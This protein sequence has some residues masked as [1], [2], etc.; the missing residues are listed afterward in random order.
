MILYL[1]LRIATFLASNYLNF[2]IVFWMHEQWLSRAFNDDV[3]WPKMRKT[4]FELT[5]EY[6]VMC[7]SFPRWKCP[8][9]SLIFA[10]I[11]RH[12]KG[13]TYLFRKSWDLFF[14]STFNTVDEVQWSSAKFKS[15]VINFNRTFLAKRHPF[16][17]EWVR[18][19]L[20]ALGLCQY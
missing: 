7:L 17:T 3:L 8:F 14:F 1:F 10:V 5:S 16:I 18:A 2:S 9:F 15:N 12:L 13:N 19:V 20:T 6:F 4:C 11:F